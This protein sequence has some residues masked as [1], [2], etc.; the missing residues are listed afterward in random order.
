MKNLYNNISIKFVTFLLCLFLVFNIS[1]IHASSYTLN[2]M[3][4]GKDSLKHIEYLS[5]ISVPKKLI[6]TLLLILLRKV[7]IV[8]KLIGLLIL[9][10]LGRLTELVFMFAILFLLSI[11][12]NEVDI[13]GHP[14]FN[15]NYY[16]VIVY[17]I[18]TNLYI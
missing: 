3:T 7:S 15:L 6:S 12:V 1:N 16:I 10:I 5:K 8:F 13:N 2:K 14:P 9:S 17:V 4:F 18:S 11:N